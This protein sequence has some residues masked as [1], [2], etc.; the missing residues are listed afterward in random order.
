MRMDCPCKE[1]KH[2][3]NGSCK[4]RHLKL[5]WKSGL[6]CKSFV[7]NDHGRMFFEKFRRLLDDVKRE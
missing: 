6:V 4:C 7:L 2:N 5:G 3:D 1:C